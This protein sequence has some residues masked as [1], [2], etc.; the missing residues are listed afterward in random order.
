MAT[1]RPVVNQ[2]E[3]HPYMT[4]QEVAGATFAK[5]LQ[6][7]SWGPLGQGKNGV[8]A[9]LEIAKVAAAHGK[10][11]AQVIIRWHLQRGLMVI[12]RSSNPAHIAENLQVFDFELTPRE[13]QVISGLNRN[14]RTFEKNDPENFPW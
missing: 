1:I 6:V 9:D 12:P 3:I 8:L 7:E 5:G 10:S 14:E 11:A 2:N 4:Q 13:M